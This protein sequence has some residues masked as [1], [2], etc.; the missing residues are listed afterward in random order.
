M[1]GAYEVPAAYK[2]I[3]TT[4]LEEMGMVGQAYKSLYEDA[5]KNYQNYTTS[6]GDFTSPIASDTEQYENETTGRLKSQIDK[7][8]DP[9]WLKT[10]EGQSMLN[11]IIATTDYGKLAKYRQSAE[12]A[13]QWLKAYQ[14]MKA[15]G[16]IND[17]WL[18]NSPNNWSTDKNGIFNDTAPME[19]ISAAQLTQPYTKDLQPSY[20]GS[21]FMNGARYNMY[22]VTKDAIFN[23]VASHFNDLVQSPQGKKYYEQSVKAALQMNPLLKGDD[24]DNA[25]K[26]IFNET[27]TDANID[28]IVSRP[29]L[30]QVYMQ[31]RKF[32]H[33][34]AMAKESENFQL[35][36]QEMRNQAKSGGSGASAGAGGAMID[37]EG[38]NGLTL[39]QQIDM[40]ADNKR[41]DKI[42][43]FG[44]FM[45]SL[46]SNKNWVKKHGDIATRRIS[47]G[48]VG[49]NNM[50]DAVNKIKQYYDAKSVYQK[51]NSQYID[52]VNKK[53]YKLA[54]KIA[55]SSQPYGK[56]IQALY[57]QLNKAAEA[58]IIKKQAD[59][60][61]R[62][63][64]I[65]PKEGR[66]YKGAFVNSIYSTINHNNSTGISDAYFSNIK[67]SLGINSKTKEGN[68]GFG[69]ATGE[70]KSP[71][72]LY[73]SIAK[74]RAYLVR[75]SSDGSVSLT[76]D[77][78]TGA[79][80]NIP[81]ALFKPD[82]VVVP[83]QSTDGSIGYVPGT[84]AIPIEEAQKYFDSLPHVGNGSIYGTSEIRDSKNFW[85]A[86]HAHSITGEAGSKRIKNQRALDKVK[87]S[88]GMD[89]MFIDDK[90]YATVNVYR[91]LYEPGPSK[92]EIN[93]DHYRKFGSSSLSKDMY[94]PT[95]EESIDEYD[96]EE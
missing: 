43:T 52:A 62:S 68:L 32:A 59:D 19:Y 56:A 72:T 82:K 47:Y 22:G 26:H 20:L 88:I 65:D 45:N 55:Y 31:D 70:Y 29:E 85:S 6:F 53:D 61:L 36:L 75:S 7:I 34:M 60:N 89:V 13:K 94:F 10:A 42:G 18:D 23:S 9:D 58:W 90:P 93:L 1:I 95:V 8:N 80:S 17:A 69:A 79:L 51:L 30:D 37:P 91:K 38:A 54:N 81:G 14:S 40:D 35:K 92:S 25:A 66:T 12:N 64:G 78:D 44:I 27:M 57:P 3:D 87:S 71:E 16:R 76:K 48:G 83:R 4:P 74:P 63:R 50:T 28:K 77:I 84:L 33:D 2:Y 96:E 11:N 5:L 24:L 46:L 41:T 21:K 73:N 49:F 39:T 15:E 67:Q 86:I